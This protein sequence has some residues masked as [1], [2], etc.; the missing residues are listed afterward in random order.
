MPTVLV[1]GAN[2]GLGLEF[3]KQYAADGWS[4]IACCR[5]PLDAPELAKVQGTIRTQSLDV[6]DHRAVD[7]LADELTGVPIDLLINN[8]GL[9]GPKGG[10]YA[11]I[12]YAAWE[13]VLRVNVMSPIKVTVALLANLLAGDLKKLVTLTSKMGSMADNGSGGAHIYRSSKAGVNAV[14]HSLALDLAPR[15]IASC[16]LHPGWVQTAMGGP[17]ALISPTESISGMRRVIENL[18]LDEV[19]GVYNYTG[20]PIPW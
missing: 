18:T 17:N 15:G 6:A 9:Y 7:R 4:V 16:L 8:A 5:N 2:R 19:G 11:D 12:D 14:M 3:V 1:T 13:E 10:S 20:D